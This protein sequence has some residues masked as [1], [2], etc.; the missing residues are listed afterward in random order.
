MPAEE[1]EQLTLVYLALSKEGKID[2]KE[3]DIILEALFSRVETGLLSGDS[4]PAMPG[5]GSLIDQVFGK[6]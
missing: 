4:S 3:R 2:E 1:R 5:V 6:K